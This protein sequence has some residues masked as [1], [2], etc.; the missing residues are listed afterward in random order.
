MK[1]LIAFDGSPSARHALKRAV[2]LFG[3]GEPEIIML[4]VVS[5][6]TTSSPGAEA[7]HAELCDEFHAEMREAAEEV[8]R[9]ELS[10]E[11]ILAEGEPRRVLEK[12]AEEKEPDV[13]VVGA[14]GQS[15]LAKVLLGSV[16][17]YAV[18]HLSVPVLLVRL[19]AGEDL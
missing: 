18:K 9:S 17:T 7:A 8:R 3:A 12:Y 2:E 10:V 14:R 5:L 11:L 19:P 4:G 6:P 1:V 15:A 13:V 16:S